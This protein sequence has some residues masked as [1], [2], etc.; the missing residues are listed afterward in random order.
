MIIKLFVVIYKRK[1][2][3][4]GQLRRTLLLDHAHGSECRVKKAEFTPPCQGTIF[5]SCS[6]ECHSEMLLSRGA[7]AFMLERERERDCY[8]KG[9][10]RACLDVEIAIIK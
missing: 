3:Q 10:L 5:H 4:R 2:Y 7:T 6:K 1:W 8:V 9:R